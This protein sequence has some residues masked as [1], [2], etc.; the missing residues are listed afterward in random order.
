MAKKKARSQTSNS[1]PDHGNLGIDSILLCVGGMQHA[2]GKLSTKAI[3]SVQTSTRSK[4][5]TKNYSPAKLRDSQ[6]LRFRD[7]HLR[8]LGQ[9]AIWMPLPR[10]SAEYTIWGKVVA[11]PES[12]PWRVLWVRGCPWLFLAPK[13]L[14][15]CANQLVCWFYASLCEWVNCLSL[16]LVPS[17]SSSTPL[18]PSKMLKARERAPNP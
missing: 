1:T 9:K 14:Q 7:S 11:S 3:T 17:Q 2:T 12:K 16:F 5:C 8:V 18:Y 13:V 4:V 6:L 10:G 15:P